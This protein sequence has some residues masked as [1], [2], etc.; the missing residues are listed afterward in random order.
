[1]HCY[2]VSQFYFLKAVRADNAGLWALARHYHAKAR[3]LLL[4]ACDTSG[5]PGDG[6]PIPAM[7]A[8]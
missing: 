8:N 4:A 6:F 7:Y 1:M 5:Q 2:H 3:R